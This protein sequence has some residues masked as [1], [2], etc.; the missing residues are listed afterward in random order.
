METHSSD[1]CDEFIRDVINEV[2][3]DAIEMTEQQVILDVI[4]DLI[5]DS[6]DLIGQLGNYKIVEP[7]TG[8]CWRWCITST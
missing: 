6:I 4:E 7:L 8:K 5:V 1:C 2:I 3:D